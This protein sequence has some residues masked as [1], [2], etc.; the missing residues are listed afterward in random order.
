MKRT[1]INR[2]SA[3]HRARRQET[4]PVREAYVRRFGFC[5]VCEH[6]PKV[7]IWPGLGPKDLNCHEILRGSGYRTKTLDEF[8]QIVVSCNECNQ[9]P[10]HCRREYPDERQLALVKRFAPDSYDLARFLELRNH[11]APLAI[12]DKAV[13]YW[14]KRDSDPISKLGRSTIDPR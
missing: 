13:D 4:S 11:N 3:K 10:L 12:S 2:E 9:G 7:I 5:W 8:C 1:R 6:R 14:V